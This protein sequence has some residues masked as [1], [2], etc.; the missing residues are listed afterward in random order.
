MIRSLLEYWNLNTGSS[1]TR[2]EPET[3]LKMSV[4]LHKNVFLHHIYMKL[5]LISHL[6]TWRHLKILGMT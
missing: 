4:F 5:N 1:K 6:K 3:D 2:I